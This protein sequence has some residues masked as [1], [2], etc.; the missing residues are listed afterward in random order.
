MSSLA[1]VVPAASRRQRRTQD[2]VGSGYYAYFASPVN[3]AAHD[4]RLGRRHL[5]R[6]GRGRPRAPRRRP[7]PG[8]ARRLLPARPARRHGHLPR[9]RRLRAA[10][11]HAGRALGRLRRLP[12]LRRGRPPRRARAGRQ[13]G[14]AAQ[15]RPAARPAAPG[16]RAGAAPVPPRRPLRPRPD[17]GLGVHRPVRGV[18]RGAGRPA[19]RVS[20]AVAQAAPDRAQGQPPDDGGLAGDRGP[21]RE[22]RPDRAA[23]ARAGRAR[24]GLPARPRRSRPASPARCRGWRPA[25]S[26]SSPATPRWCR[27]P[28]CP[29]GCRSRRSSG[30]GPTCCPGWST[31]TASASCWCTPRSSGRW[32]SAGRGCTGWRPASSSAR[33]RCCPT[34]RTPRRWSPRVSSFP[35]CAD[36]VINSRYDPDTD[37]ASA[38]EPHVGSHGGL[39]GPQQFGFLAYPRAWPP[40]GEIVGAEQLHRVLRGWLTDLGHPEPTGDGAAVGEESRTALEGEPVSSAPRP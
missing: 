38:F 12:R 34:A 17:P 4:R 2:R 15:H 25:W 24:P 11:G 31:T 3:A 35:H 27:S 23:A 13:P 20:R 6:A 19:V 1:H 22:R 29:G 32:C 8:V 9:R 10:R 18:D 39:G 28:T 30:T 7:P 16:Q 40:P 26:A 14:R 33:T 36:V 5:P 37:E 21:R